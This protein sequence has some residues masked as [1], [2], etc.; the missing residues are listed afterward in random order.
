MKAFRLI[1]AAGCSG[2]IS[3]YSS[4]CLADPVEVTGELGSPNA[5]TTIDG[6]QLPPP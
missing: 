5:T 3:L 4:F 1:V 6:K 2:V